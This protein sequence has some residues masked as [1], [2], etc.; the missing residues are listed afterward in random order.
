MITA[1]QIAA[2]WTAPLRE[3][4][5]SIQHRVGVSGLQLFDAQYLCRGLSTRGAA[6]WINELTA[7]FGTARDSLE[8]ARRRYPRRVRHSGRPSKLIPLE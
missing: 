1:M 4:Y 8:F 7:R 5:G 2:I 3:T 6:G